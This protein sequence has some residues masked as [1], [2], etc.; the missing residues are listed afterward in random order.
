MRGGATYPLP[1]NT[2]D[3]KYTREDNDRYMGKDKK[4]KGKNGNSYEKG[5]K[6]K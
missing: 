3:R 6:R 1:Q 4:R 2:T 5:M